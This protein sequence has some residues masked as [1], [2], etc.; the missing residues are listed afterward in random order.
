MQIQL[1]NLKHY[2]F[3]FQYFL[4]VLARLHSVSADAAEYLAKATAMN[5]PIIR[6]LTAKGIRNTVN[7]LKSKYSCGYDE[8]TT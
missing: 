7:C 8:M 3:L 4:T 6:R 5:F 2:N 1:K